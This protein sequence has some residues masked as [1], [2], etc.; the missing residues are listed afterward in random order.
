MSYVS[1]RT[2]KSSANRGPT[3]VASATADAR[4]LV[5]KYLPD[6]QGVTVKSNGAADP[7]TLAPR[8]RTV[9]TWPDGLTYDHVKLAIAITE[10]PG[11]LNAKN[12][13]CSVTY[14]RTA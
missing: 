3:T 12:D 8:V 10:L 9:I 6:V 13:T 2:V 7:V 5:R 1:G 14:V 11:Y 4:R